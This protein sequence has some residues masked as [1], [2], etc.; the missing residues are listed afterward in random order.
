VRPFPPRSRRLA[1]RL[2][3]PRRVS[4]CFALGIGVAGLNGVLAHNSTNTMGDAKGID[5]VE[6]SGILPAVFAAEKCAGSS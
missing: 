6:E 1:S 2:P 4:R 3:T 5:H